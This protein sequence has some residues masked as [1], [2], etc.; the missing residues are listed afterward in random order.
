MSGRENLTVFTYKAFPLFASSI[1][2]CQI[3]MQVFQFLTSYF[4]FDIGYINALLVPVVNYSSS[5]FVVAGLSMNR[6]SGVFNQPLDCGLFWFSLFMLYMY[7]PK[8]LDFRKLTK[9][10]SPTVFFWKW[11]APVFSLLG[12][13][14][15]G[16][17]IFL[18]I[19]VI[20]LIRSLFSFQRFCSRL[21]ISRQTIILFFCAICF[22][23]FIF[24]LLFQS[25]QNPLVTVFL[26]SDSAFA[27]L[28]SPYNLS[29]GRIS[30]SGAIVKFNISDFTLF[31]SGYHSIIYDNGY[32][33]IL[34]HIGL[35]GIVSFILFAFSSLVSLRFTEYSSRFESLVLELLFFLF[36]LLLVV[37]GSVLTLHKASIFFICCLMYVSAS[38]SVFSRCHR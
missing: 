29:A 27:N 37:G 23:A 17:K 25:T 16:S 4:G 14:L 26:K 13:F 9:D 5:V 30:P 6:F 32:L 12:C 21:K 2:C 38:R 11:L 1:S 7:V 15:C 36:L 8:Y 20:L 31:G 34:K 19:G 3:I 18:L 10:F 24:P 22:L 35:I 28:F 33:Y